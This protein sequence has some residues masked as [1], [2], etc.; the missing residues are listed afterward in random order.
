MN[1]HGAIVSILS[2]VGAAIIAVLA[3]SAW[4]LLV[5]AMGLMTVMW[6]SSLPIENAGIIDIVWGPVFALM[7]F[8][9][10]LAFD[11]SLDPVTIGALAM[12]TLWAVRLGLH[13]AVRNL[14]KPEDFR[15]RKFREAAGSSF[16][17]RSLFTIFWLQALLAWV[18]FGPV[19]GFMLAEPVSW[20]IA[21][22]VGLALFVFGF[23]FE[24]IADWQLTRFKADPANKGKVLSTG[25]WG[26]SRHPN[27]FGE[28]V[29]WWG[30]F[31]FVAPAGGWPFVIGPILI[32]W[33]L[34]KVSGVTMLEKG[35]AKQK[36]AYQAYVENV[37]TFFP[38]L[39]GT[40]S[41]SQPSQEHSA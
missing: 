1:V 2:L 33:M 37:P 11:R 5:A 24:T 17:I 36:P 19:I 21:Q 34:M 3:P 22:S 31:V 12:V 20:G 30:I 18:V 23:L 41:R 7:G 4:V 15:Y 25:L 28:A 32:T 39:P 38:K 26:L 35:L 9:G 29:L 13:L 16:A 8:V 6:L 27:Y 14:G 40:G 10:V